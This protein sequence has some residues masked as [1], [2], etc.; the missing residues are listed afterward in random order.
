MQDLANIYTHIDEAYTYC[1]PSLALRIEDCI[2]HDSVIY[3]SDG[4][5]AS[6]FYP[7]Y[8]TNDVPYVRALESSQGKAVRRF[9]DRRRRFFYLSSSGSF[10]YGHWLVDDL[11]RAKWLLDDPRPTTIALQSYPGMDNIRIE[12]LKIFLKGLK[13]NFVLLKPQDVVSC[14]GLT[15]VTPVSFHPYVKN[16]A[17]LNCLRAMMRERVVPSRGRKYER[18]FV[19]RRQSRGRRLINQPEIEAVLFR[20]GFR[21][22]DPEDHGFAEQVAIFSQAKLI[23]G[24]MCAAMCNSIFAEKGT[25]LVYLAPD[26]WI[27]PFYWDLASALGHTYS[28]LYGNRAHINPS[29]PFDDF[30]IE[31]ERLEALLTAQLVSSDI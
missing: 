6:P 26:G 2:I 10:N 7:T 25:N 4:S 11:A 16:A 3:L 30:S 13:V 1:A 22:V 17:A 18:L 20:L 29:P 19:H 8:R 31:A 15:Y 5:L 9:D 21:I 27:E 14:R 24:T 28:A 12:T 23:V